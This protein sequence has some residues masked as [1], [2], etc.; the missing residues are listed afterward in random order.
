MTE[1]TAEAQSP[2]VEKVVYTTEQIMEIIP[3]RYPF[4]LIDKIVEFED[5]VRV[6]GIK[7][8]SANEPFFQ[9][10]FPGRPVM[11]GVLII[12]AMAQTAAVFAKKSTG[13][14]LPNKTVFLVG[15]NDMR[16]KQM[17]LPG[18]TMRIEMRSYK[19][20]RPLWIMDG[21]VWVNGKVVAT[22]QISA[23]ESD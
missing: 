1:N 3:H 8:V 6:V 11:P 22:G 4:L 2:I 21:T 7:N 16:F 5:A 15:A 19:R 17:V 12:E 20:K 9:G 18:D 23:V 10:H 13:G 14:V